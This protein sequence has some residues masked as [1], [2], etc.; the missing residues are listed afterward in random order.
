MSFFLKYLKPEVIIPN[1]PSANLSIMPFPDYSKIKVQRVS[2]LSS[3][4][5]EVDMLRLDLLHEEISGNKWFKLKYN[6]EEAKIENK[7]TILTFGGAWSNHIAATAAACD[8]LGFKSI[9]LIR[10]DEL[11]PD[12]SITL[13]CATHHG[14]E[15]HFISREE[16]RRKEDSDFIRVI[17]EK[18]NYP[19][20]IPE[21]GNNALG[22]KGCMEILSFCQKEK[23]SYVCC[24][25]GTGATLSGI[26]ES[27]LPHQKIIG[28]APFKNAKEQN[29]R[30][31]IFLSDN[32]KKYNREIIT[33]YH[34]GG[35]GKKTKELLEFMN[36]FYA[37]NQVQLDFVYTGKMMFGIYDLIM[38]G[39][40]RSGSKIIAIHTGGLQG[41]KSFSEESKGE[42]IIG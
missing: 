19:Y 29:E 21:G 8:L 17:N 12:S 37:Q 40:F 13:S 24:A 5:V 41:N 4:K 10:G 25:V 33:D 1:Q 6:L 14:M 42:R 32:L 11:K 38:K 34:F 23:Y 28:F 15:L 30:I 36:Q 31:K 9:G 20:T 26:I 22:R 35:F 18:F 3:S 2:S 16:Y 27:C 7:N 39:F